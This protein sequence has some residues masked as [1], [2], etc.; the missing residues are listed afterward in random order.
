MNENVV[1]EIGEKS[2]GRLDQLIELVR[3]SGSDSRFLW[4]T[5]LG[6]LIG[7][8]ATLCATWLQQKHQSKIH[9]DTV[10]REEGKRKSEFLRE[11]SEAAYMEAERLPLVSSKLIDSI[12]GMYVD[13]VGKGIDLERTRRQMLDSFE[14]LDAASPAKLRLLVKPYLQSAGELLAN[15]ETKHFELLKSTK[16]S[17]LAL[18][19]A[20]TQADAA[21]L[22]VQHR[23]AQS[24]AHKAFQQALKALKVQLE[25]DLKEQWLKR[26]G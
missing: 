21:G 22:Y 10:R 18:L 19:N 23:T 13:A 9:R 14:H 1:L 25:S 2:L 17:G 11:K 12:S 8:T 5:A 4:G 16:A 7:A 24:D 26:G 15:V 3:A 20:S 6:G